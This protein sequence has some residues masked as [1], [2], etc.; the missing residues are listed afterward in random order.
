MEATTESLTPEGHRKVSVRTKLLFA[1]G[2]LQEAAVTAGGLTTMLF[3]NQ[4]LGVSGT[5]AGTAFLIA[6][7]SDAVTDP[8]V[9]AFSDNFKS[10]WG[11]R[12]PL[13]LASILPIAIGF[14]LLYQPPADL[15]EFGY[16]LWL[17]TFLVLL[18][19]GQTLYLIPHD[20][21]GAELT[22]DYEGRTLIFA[23]NAVAQGILTITVV[24]VVTML[25]FPSNEQFEN[26][27]LNEAA[28][29]ILAVA[30]CATIIFSVLLCTLGTLDQIPHLHQI[31]NK[32][33]FELRV[34][35]RGLG[36]LLSSRSYLAACISILTI[37]ISI[38][39]IGIVAN[40]AYLYVFELT[41]QQ[42]FWASVAK[43]PG[44]LVA[45]PLLA[46]VGTR[47]EKKNIVI[48]AVVITA[49]FLSLPHNLSMLGLFPGNDS[50]WVL[51]GLF[52]PLAIGYLIFPMATI[53]LDSQLADCADEHDMRSGDRAE[54][55]IFAVRSFALK[56]T[57]GIGAFIAGVAL[58]IIRF[59][60]NA[61]MGML[62][63]FTVDG[64]LFLNGP[65]F[66]II[67]LIAAY[68]MSFYAIDKARHDEILQT[69]KER[70]ETRGS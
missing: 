49:V 30:G 69:L 32:K 50:P 44:I 38:G 15:S 35:L 55:A 21:L 36:V 4:L 41:T 40:Y 33:S 27:L 11:R 62:E 68:A 60:D 47:F 56:T 39:I 9:G 57:N 17:T 1:S 3:Y 67:Y 22:Q 19:I 5:L 58:D 48:A 10:R 45:L 6:N 37:Y 29:F 59:P 25:I 46:Y 54:G 52:V 34:Y 13:M 2:T 16:F 43:T 70:N 14:Y 42:L 61:E 65:L 28:Y 31:S 24:G 53:T 8:L 12:H 20:A 23:Y 7:I 51:I 63:P 64:L 18:R 26:G 66:L